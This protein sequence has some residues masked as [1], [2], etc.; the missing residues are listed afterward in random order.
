MNIVPQYAYLTDKKQVP[1][2]TSN[3]SSGLRTSGQDKIRLVQLPANVTPV[4]RIESMLDSAR[5]RR[6]IVIETIGARRE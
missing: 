6:T 4:S 3:T 1:F 5:T 2:A